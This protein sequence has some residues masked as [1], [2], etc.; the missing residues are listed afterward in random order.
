MERWV[1][2]LR[3]VNV[4]KAGAGRKAVPMA[5]LRALAAELGWRGAQ[6]YIQSGNLVFAADGEAA[7]LAAA[8]ERAIAARWDFDVPV[9]VSGLAELSALLD[10]CPFPEA[11]ATRP[12]LVHVG[13]TGAELPDAAVEVLE[14]YCVAG[15][16]VVAD[17]AALWIDFLDGVGRSKLTPAVLERAAG[18]PVTSRNLKTLRAVREIASR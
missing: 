8:L 4:G 6:T 17:G 2:W 5:E 12:Q 14:P 15:E 9:V 10:A 3:G 13:F 7:A 11:A 16:Q 18:G 1:A